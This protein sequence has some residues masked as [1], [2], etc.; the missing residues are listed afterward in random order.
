M[1]AFH[2][3]PDL[4]VGAVR[5]VKF[6]KYLP[7]F[8][9][10]VHVV[11]VASEYYERTDSSPLP[12]ECAVHRAGMWPTLL[13]AAS[14]LKK[15]SARW[16]R[17]V[18]Q[19]DADANPADAQATAPGTAR[20]GSFWQRLVVNLGTTPD[21][22]VGW[23]VP[24][25][26]LAV[27]VVRREHIDVIYSSGPPHTGH[28]V[29]FLASCLTGRPLVTDFR[30]PWT[31]QP[32]PDA[33]LDR[34]FFRIERML[35]S[36]IV[37]R[38]RLVLG[39][40]QA[41]CQRLMA[42]HHPRLATKCVALLNGYDAEDFTVRTLPPERA[43]GRV[44][45][46]VYA[47]T[48]YAGRNPVAFLRVLGE[49]ISEGRVSRNAIVVEFYGSVEIE[50]APLQSVIDEL[51]LRDVVA[52][53]GSVGREEYLRLLRNADVLIL[54]QGDETP[55]AIPAKA[56][57]YLATGNEIL[58]L[59]GSHAVA[60][61]LDGYENVHRAALE[62]AETIRTCITT[63]IDRITSGARHR[64]GARGSLSHL[65]KRELTREFARLLDTASSSG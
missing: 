54:I 23:L 8:G 53:R 51:S 22:F 65:H 56:F 10:Q 34:V 52:F 1:V 59:A 46:F 64:E 32:A 50:A 47:G 25:T 21:A 38:S 5:S 48:L 18:R 33:R 24:A 29:G 39:S 13:T 28:I 11:S 41:I 20:H 35:E 62:D 17:R 42:A 43:A 49:M 63:I 12:F 60:E 9:W 36:L 57:E 16:S 30:D 19:A 6:A 45:S 61:L 14:W 31:T 2:F 3:H 44:I 55:W 58:L 26:S 40:T 4:E 27:S 7:E 37:R 15:K